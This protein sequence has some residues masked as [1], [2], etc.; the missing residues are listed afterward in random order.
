MKYHG[1]RF[2]S[3]LP[4]KLFARNFSFSKDDKLFSILQTGVVIYAIRREAGEVFNDIKFKPVVTP[5]REMKSAHHGTRHGYLMENIIDRYY[6]GDAAM[7]TEF[8]EDD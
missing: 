5:L 6:S 8:F 3:A 7:A 2:D 4:G 1:F